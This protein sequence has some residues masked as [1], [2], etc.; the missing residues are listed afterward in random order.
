MDYIYRPEG[1]PKPREHESQKAQL[2]SLPH[3]EN[4]DVKRKIDYKTGR[5]DWEEKARLAHGKEEQRKIQDHVQNVRPLKYC[6]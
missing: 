5:K 4:K 1:S 3:G 6:R 2:E